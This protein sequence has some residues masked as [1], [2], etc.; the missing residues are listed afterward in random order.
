MIG[1]KECSVCQLFCFESFELAVFT[2]DEFRYD[3]FEFCYLLL[4]DSF[5]TLLKLGRRLVSPP[6][7]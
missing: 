3:N 4:H 1:L 7:N 5:E 6:N 2:F